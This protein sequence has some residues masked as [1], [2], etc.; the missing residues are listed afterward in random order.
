MTASDA[1]SLDFGKAIS[2]D[3]FA[4]FMAAGVAIIT[5]GSLHSSMLVGS[6]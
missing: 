3:S 4:R 2:G 5:A 6:R 1:I